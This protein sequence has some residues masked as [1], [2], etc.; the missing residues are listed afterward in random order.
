MVT[1][2]KNTMQ[3]S[4]ES[5]DKD[6]KSALV[7][8]YFD[9]GGAEGKG[10]KKLKAFKAS[11]KS[12]GHVF[13][14][15]KKFISVRFRSL[16]TC[17]EP[18]LHNFDE[19]VHF[20]KSVKKPTPRQEKLITYF[21]ERESVSKLNLMFIFAATLNLTE[22]IDFF[23]SNNLNIHNSVDVIENVYVDQLRKIVC[24]TEIMKL[25]GEEI[26][27][28]TKSELIK[29]DVDNTKL[30]TN[31]EIFIGRECPTEIRSLGL[32]P[33]S[34]KLSWFYDKVKTFHKTAVKYLLKYFSTALASPILDCFTA[35]S[36][37]KQSHLLTA[38]KL[39][40]LA[41][42]YSKVVNN[43]DACDGMDKIFTEIDQYQLD[44]DVKVLDKSLNYEDYWSKVANL[45]LGSSDWKKYEVLPLFAVGL[46]IK[47]ISN[48]EVE[49]KF[50]LM[51]NIFQNNNEISFHRTV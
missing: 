31:K 51:N 10:L 11:C 14:P 1:N 34:S 42:K 49:R 29:I 45:E 28:K 47:F 12:W 24:E 38:R 32:S 43:I 20:Y 39:K 17:I 40:N 36:P 23:E 25:E 27:R 16:R 44:E 30:L 41:N 33:S 48:S 35:L 13:K 9:L 2:L 50:S 46:A 37:S 15:F 5:Y 4:V 21:V 6:M 22:K 3:H 26:V 18:V 19:L 8:L 7:D